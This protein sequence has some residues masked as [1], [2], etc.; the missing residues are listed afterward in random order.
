[1]LPSRVPA[2]S[3]PAAVS[4]QIVLRD[5]VKRFELP[6]ED[7]TAVDRVTLT[8]GWGEFLCI[9]GPSGC[10]KTTVLRILAELETASAGEVIV[11]YR[12]PDRPRTAMV[13][14]GDS[15]LPWMSVKDNVTFA[16]LNQRLSAAQRKEIVGYYLDRVGLTSFAR[17]YPRQLSGG[18]KQRVSIARAFATDPEIL[19]MD[20]P[21]AA[22]DEQNK[23]LLEEEL[24]RIWEETRKTVVYI[25]HSIEEAVTLGDRVIVMTAH[26]GRI[27][28][29]IPIDF[30]RPRD[31]HELKRQPAFADYVY[32]I[33]SELREEVVRATTGI[34]GRAR[35]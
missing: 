20:E 19:L 35:S 15:V 34:G 30:D 23:L 5:V 17:A 2:Q 3:P 4:G 6:G 31:I 22:L 9:V 32:R 12:R 27:K 8:V 28:S 29:S 14:Q 7:I 24:L 33:W 16:L 11:Y 10:G 13:F 26:P 18:M 25:T 21:F 1:M